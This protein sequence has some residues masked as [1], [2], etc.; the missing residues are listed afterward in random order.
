MADKKLINIED[1]VANS[2]LLELATHQLVKLT[3]E[4]PDDI[5]LVWQLAET[6]RKQGQLQKSAQ[7]YSKLCEHPNQSQLFQDLLSITSGRPEDFVGSD[8]CHPVPFI[9]KR[10]YLTHNELLTLCDYIK[11]EAWQ[12]S[13]LSRV[14]NGE[15]DE[16]LRKS[17][18]L[19]M[20]DWL[21]Q[22]MRKDI[23]SSLPEL[24]SALNIKNNNFERIDLSLRSY[25]NGDFFGIH[26]D[27]HPK[28]QRKLS[29]TYFFYI[30]PKKF[31]GG[32]LL[33]F[34]TNINQPENRSFSESF[35]RLKVTQNT[36]AIFP[37]ASYHAVSTVRAETEST[38][39]Y[40]YAVNAHIWENSSND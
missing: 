6:Y 36:L 3:S 9:L 13:D 27:N 19:P 30:E 21:K 14:R 4:N 15:Y 31:S 20:P 25:G 24:A 18:D 5:N 32:D 8:D 12:S 40:R 22:R 17:Y 10:D 35:T 38:T 29:M 39:D 2:Q 23:T 7:L 37:S 1:T 16:N 11:T 26:T 33:I 28:I 34:D